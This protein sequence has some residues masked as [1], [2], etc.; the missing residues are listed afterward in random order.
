[1]GLVRGGLA[2]AAVLAVGAMAVSIPLGLLGIPVLAI[3]LVVVQIVF[4]ELA[5]RLSASRRWCPTVMILLTHLVSI[6]LWSLLWSGTEYGSA[7]PGIFG[8]LWMLH[9]LPIVLQIVQ[10]TLRWRDADR[11]IRRSLAN[12]RS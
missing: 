1:V 5:P 8:F 6:S 11:A 4:V 9:A 7:W 12:G 10:A 3:P 2:G